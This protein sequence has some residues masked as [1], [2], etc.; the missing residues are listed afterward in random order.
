MLIDA[1]M[2]AIRTRGP[3]V[4]LDEMAAVA[5]VS[6]PSFYRD[7]GDKQG[8]ADAI[9]V[10]IGD[11]LQKQ[12]VDELLGG[13]QVDVAGLVTAFIEAIVDLIDT[14]PELYAFLVRS[15]RASD[16][17]FLDNALVGAVHERTAML[18]GFVAPKLDPAE[19]HL[20]TDAVFG[21]VFGAVESW[22]ANRTVTKERLVDRL[23]VVITA[24]LARIAEE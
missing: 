20:L 3:D 18:V 1:A 16:R 17:G 21:L 9:A 24:G 5:G 15:I 12:V 2:E 13:R 6:K 8:V 14:E 7:L 22:Q 11:R 19:L 10:E 23:S 4:S